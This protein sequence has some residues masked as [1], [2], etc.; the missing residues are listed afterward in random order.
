MGSPDCTAETREEGSREV[1]AAASPGR[2]AASGVAEHWLMSQTDE[3]SA[4]EWT[5][6]AETVSSEAVGFGVH[7]L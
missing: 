2:W 5:L 3:R 6:G 7:Q 1:R 4:R